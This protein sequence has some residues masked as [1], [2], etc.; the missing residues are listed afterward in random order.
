MIS[1]KGFAIMDD[2]FKLDGD[3]YYGKYI[4]L[5]F[6][7]IYQT[8]EIAEDA[9]KKNLRFY[10]SPQTKKIKEVEVIIK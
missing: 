5:S 10:F 6:S 4:F 2:N 1:I 9:L 8:R 7:E 3:P